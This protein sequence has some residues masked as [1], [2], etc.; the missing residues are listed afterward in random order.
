MDA[1]AAGFY[2][3]EA[4]GALVGVEGELRLMMDRFRVMTPFAAEGASF[5]ED[6]GADPRAIMEGKSLYVDNNS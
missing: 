1:C 6:S 3:P 4:I 2:A 5:E